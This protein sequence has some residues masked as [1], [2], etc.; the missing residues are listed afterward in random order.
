MLVAATRA[1]PSRPSDALTHQRRRCSHQAATWAFST[2]SAVA[3]TTSQAPSTSDS[4]T[5]RATTETSP[6][7]A[8]RSASSDGLRVDEHHQ[9]AVVDQPSGPTR[10]DGAGA[11]DEDAAAGEVQPDEGRHAGAVRSM[12]TRP[13]STLTAYTAKSGPRPGSGTLSTASRQRPSRSEKT[14]L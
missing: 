4:T 1:V 5:P 6:W 14:C 9:R 7:L 12:V 10:A 13:S 2:G 3:A 11:H 8:I